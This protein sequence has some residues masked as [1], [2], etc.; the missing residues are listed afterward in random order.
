MDITLHLVE[1]QGSFAYEEWSGR[2]LTVDN[3]SG[4]LFL[5]RKG[6]PH[7][8][9]YH[10]LIVRKVQTWPYYNPDY[11]EF[12][13]SDE[14]ARLV[15]VIQG[16]SVKATKED[17]ARVAQALPA[18]TTEYHAEPIDAMG[19]PSQ[20]EEW[21]HGIKLEV[22]TSWMKKGSDLWIVRVGSVTALAELIDSLTQHVD[23]IFPPR[24]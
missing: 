4:C 1:K 11:I 16:R 13:F 23:S 12:R 2:I 22:P 20:G 9:T 3:E 10:K 7:K 19:F 15:V 14:S 18:V 8:R 24:K 21:E 17:A 5:S 6:A